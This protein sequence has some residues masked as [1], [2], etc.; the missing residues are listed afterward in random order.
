MHLFLCYFKSD[1]VEFTCIDH[2][3]KALLLSTL[4]ASFSFISEGC[5]R[6]CPQE[7]LQQ[8]LGTLFWWMVT[9][10]GLLMLNEPCSSC[11][12][13]ML[14]MWPQVCTP[15]PCGAPMSHHPHLRLAPPLMSLVCEAAHWWL[16]DKASLTSHFPYASSRVC[17]QT[18]GSG[19]TE[20]AHKTRRGKC[21][22]GHFAHQVA[23]FSAVCFFFCI[24]SS[25]K[26]FLWGGRVENAKHFHFV[27]FSFYKYSIY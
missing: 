22:H 23:I 11:F 18:N 3:R 2:Y 27:R 1:N 24:L 8:H 21:Q 13:W 20:F 17:K 16:M 7:A 5:V 15:T 6:A 9:F 26:Q 10:I 19:L 12:N 4:Y 25:G 14:F